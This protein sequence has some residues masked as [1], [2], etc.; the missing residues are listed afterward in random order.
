MSFLNDVEI[1]KFKKI[2]ANYEKIAFNIRKKIFKHI[3]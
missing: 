3:Q 1:K 2:F